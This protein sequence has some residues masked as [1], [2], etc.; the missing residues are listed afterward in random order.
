MQP[1]HDLVGHLIKLGGHNELLVFYRQVKPPS[2]QLYVEN[3]RAHE[4]MLGCQQSIQG[5]S[6][7]IIGA[8]I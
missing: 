2:R 5:N 3:H 1:F 7:I 6:S 4:V 8:S